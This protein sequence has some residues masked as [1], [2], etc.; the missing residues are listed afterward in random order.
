MTNDPNIIINDK[1]SNTL[2]GFT[3]LQRESSLPPLRAYTVDHYDS[4]F[5]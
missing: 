5:F 2:I 4:I 1:A 3:S